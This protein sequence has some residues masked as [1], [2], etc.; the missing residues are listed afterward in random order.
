M[1]TRVESAQTKA[2]LPGALQTVAVSEDEMSEQE[3]LCFYL[4]IC[5]NFA[6][7]AVL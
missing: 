1:E 5:A 3:V 6:E 4:T 7:T 2:S